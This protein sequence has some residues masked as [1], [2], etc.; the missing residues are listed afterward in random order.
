MDTVLIPGPTFSTRAGSPGHVNMVSKWSKNRSINNLQAMMWD[1]IGVSL[2]V[3]LLETRV[4][5]DVRVSAPRTTPPSN[6][7]ATK[8]VPVDTSLGAQSGN[9]GW[10]I[11]KECG[12]SIFD[13]MT[14]IYWTKVSCKCSTDFKIDIIRRF[15]SRFFN[16]CVFSR[17]RF[18]QLKSWETL[19]INVYGCMKNFKA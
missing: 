15:Y 4:P 2:S 16:L 19:L 10:N 14:C 13:R 1:E 17:C 9:S 7:T 6:S 12:F 5:I 3:T 11:F 8:V 18:L